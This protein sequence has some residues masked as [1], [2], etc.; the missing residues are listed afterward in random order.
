MAI[1]VAHTHFVHAAFVS[2]LVRSNDMQPNEF[3]WDKAV[4]GDSTGPTN[5]TRP[6]NLGTIDLQKIYK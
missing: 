2:S 3:S 5:G 4:R 1:I 6:E